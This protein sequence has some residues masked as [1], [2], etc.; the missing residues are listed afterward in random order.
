MKYRRF[1]RT[2]WDVSEMG[3]GMWG[4][5]GWTGTEQTEVNQALARSVELGCNF[6][7]TAWGYGA[8]ASEQILG[9]LLRQ[10]AGKRLY[11]ATKIPPANF[12][13]PSKPEFRLEDVFPACAY[14]RVY[15][16]KSQQSECGMYRPSA[17]SRMGR[18]LGRP[19]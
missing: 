2:G 19:R 8:G 4:L 12:K 17:V 3:Y 5:A 10:H 15:R 18:W 9:R 11:F 7:D 6:F 14:H 13:W 1:G 16:E